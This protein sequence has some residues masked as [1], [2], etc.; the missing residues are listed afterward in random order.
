MHAQ[1]VMFTR[2]IGAIAVASLVAA[3]AYADNFESDP[4]APFATYKTYAWTS[5]TPSPDP[6]TERR[7]HA[8]VE[9][10][11]SAKVIRLAAPD[12]TPDIYVA[13][14]VVTQGGAKTSTLSAASGAA[15]IEPARYSQGAL[16]I[17]VFDAHTQKMAW[18]GVASGTES[19]KPSKNADKIEKALIK[20]FQ[21]YPSSAN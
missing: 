16:V 6:I 13:T 17:D 21:R 12:E 3:G 9:A 7:I 11:M 10:Q 1:V 15:T 5:G 4:S 2:T 14:H 20:L 8:A 19:D 18:R